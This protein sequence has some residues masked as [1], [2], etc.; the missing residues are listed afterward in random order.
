MNMEAES[1]RTAKEPKSTPILQES[2]KEFSSEISEGDELSP[3]PPV[4]QDKKE[5]FSHL[6]Q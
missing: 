3:P 1:S 2:L 5:E 6:L 4:S